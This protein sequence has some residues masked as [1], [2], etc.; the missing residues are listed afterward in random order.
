MTD[1]R[2]QSQQGACMTSR[3]S[4]GRSLAATL[5]AIAATF[6][7]G[8]ASAQT[9]EPSAEL[10]FDRIRRT[11]VLR[12]AALPGEQPFFRTDCITY[13]IFQALGVSA[14]APMLSEVTM[15]QQPYVALPSAMGLQEEPDRCWRDYVNAWTEY[16]RGTRQI[17]GWI[18]DAL[19]VMGVK[20]ESIP[21]NADL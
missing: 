5:G 6:A 17:G 3:R 13:A 11:G 21:A 2:N 8:K 20:P 18:H 9:R 12:I 1:N 14:K 19:L 7:I 4:L 15:L 16:N 10:T